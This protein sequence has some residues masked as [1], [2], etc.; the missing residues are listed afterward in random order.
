[1][2]WSI[3]EAE[4]KAGNPDAI[5]E[6]KIRC[7][8]LPPIDGSTEGGLGSVQ[9]S[10]AEDGSPNMSRHGQSAFLAAESTPSKFTNGGND[11]GLHTAPSS[12]FADRSAPAIGTDVNGSSLSSG[13]NATAPATGVV[14]KLQAAGVPTNTSELKTAATSAANT[15]S[16][17]ASNAAASVGLASQP[18]SGLTAGLSSGAS[19][20]DS[21]QRDL[22]AAR[23]EIEKLKTTIREK[24]SE[25]LRQRNVGSAVSSTSSAVGSQVATVKQEGIPAQMVAAL[26]FGV[27]LFTW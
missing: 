23:A 17:A 10:A 18:S 14:E 2:Q 13:Q 21:L 9:E 1:M 24:E 4:H 27:F 11:D 12:A 20:S 5:A 25:G 15:V 16:N 22:S 7:A 6:Q 3:V 26:C 19:T 8:F